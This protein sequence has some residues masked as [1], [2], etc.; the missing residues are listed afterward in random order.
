MF[1]KPDMQD[2]QLI[3]VGGPLDGER[4][5]RQVDPDWSVVRYEYPAESGG[6]LRHVYA[7]CRASSSETEIP[8]KYLGVRREGDEA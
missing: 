7:G 1:R 4:V 3:L 6:K 2:A 5:R 8:M